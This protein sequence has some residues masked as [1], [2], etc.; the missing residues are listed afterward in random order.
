M[1]LNIRM[2]NLEPT[3]SLRRHIERRL[4]FALAPFNGR[5]RQV[6]VR[7]SDLNGPRGGCDKSCH[8]AIRLASG[9]GTIL[10]TDTQDDVYSAISGAMERA[11]RAVARQLL[12]H[13]Q[14]RLGR[15]NA[16]RSRL[17]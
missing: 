16:N 1:R 4:Q 17:D 10:V 12:W 3:E 9:D 11:G 5:I 2:R 13:R 7:V 8:V 15:F 6:T 14:L